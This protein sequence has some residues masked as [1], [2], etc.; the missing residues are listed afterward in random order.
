MT[1]TATPVEKK[2]AEISKLFRRDGRN[3]PGDYAVNVNGSVL[4]TI[5]AQTK[6]EFCL[7]NGKVLEAGVHSFDF[8]GVKLSVEVK[9]IAPGTTFYDLNRIEPDY[10]ENCRIAKRP[11][12]RMELQEKIARAKKHNDTTMSEILNRVVVVEA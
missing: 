5:N 12:D 2:K 3:E 8:N 6:A 1:Q 11:V 7:W 4:G 10:L 9:D